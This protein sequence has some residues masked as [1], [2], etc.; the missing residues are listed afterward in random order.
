MIEVGFLIRPIA[1]FERSGDVLYDQVTFFMIK[2]DFFGDHGNI[3]QDRGAIQDQATF[4]VGG[5]FSSIR[6]NF[7]IAPTF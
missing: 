5:H 2:R 4:E 6:R 1:F 3:F 7:L